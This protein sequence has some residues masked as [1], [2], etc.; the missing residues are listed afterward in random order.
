MILDKFPRSL[1][2]LKVLF[3]EALCKWWGEHHS[4]STPVSVT[5]AKI[6]GI[7]G[8]TCNVPLI[9]T[10]LKLRNCGEYVNDIE[11]AIGTSALAEAAIG[12]MLPAAIHHRRSKKLQ[13]LVRFIDD[14]PAIDKECV[15]HYAKIVLDEA[16]KCSDSSSLNDTYGSTNT[17][18][19]L[20]SDRDV[21]GVEEDFSLFYY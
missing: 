2:V 16:Y 1:A 13:A 21:D 20:E 7:A 19:D 10:V 17:F 15:S 4:P 5:F 3:D 18:L 11:H 12:W 14:H 8:V 9:T 6:E